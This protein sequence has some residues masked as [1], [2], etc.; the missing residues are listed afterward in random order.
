VQENAETAKGTFTCLID[1]KPFKATIAGAT[2]ENKL[3]DGIL[4]VVGTNDK[5][6]VELI[7][8]EKEVKNSAV[9]NG[10]GGVG[11]NTTDATKMKSYVIMPDAQATVKISTRTTT[12][13][14]GTFSFTAVD[15]V[16]GGKVTVTE[17]KFN[18]TI[19][20]N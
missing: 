7:L 6:A 1:G 15:D 3:S 18:V 16:S 17:G 19:E 2:I 14:S 11:L 5:D 13:V 20:K 8:T 12:Q 9:I 4:Q 10:E